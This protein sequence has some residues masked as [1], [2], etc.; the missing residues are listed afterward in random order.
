M[1]ARWAWT[2][3]DVTPLS[4]VRGGATSVAAPLRLTPEEV[5]DRV[6]GRGRRRL[7]VLGAGLVVA[8]DSAQQVRAGGVERVVAIEVESGAPPVPTV[9]CADLT[10]EPQRARSAGVGPSSRPLRHRIREQ[11]G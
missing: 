4:R 1:S 8:S 11:F 6:V 5:P 3:V 2:A 10:L 7:P 9:A